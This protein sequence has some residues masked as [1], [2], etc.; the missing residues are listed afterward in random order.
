LEVYD[1][2][3]GRGGCD[4]YDNDSDDITL[5]LITYLKL[6]SSEILIDKLIIAQLVKNSPPFMEPAFNTNLS[7]S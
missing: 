4:N 6:K 1:D 7:C 3:G 5:L 2:G